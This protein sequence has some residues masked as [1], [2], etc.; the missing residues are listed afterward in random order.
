MKATNGKTI[1]QFQV[2]LNVY[3]STE[4][5]R[6]AIEQVSKL[7]LKLTRI[8]IEYYTFLDDSFGISLLNQVT[9]N[10]ATHYCGF[11]MGGYGESGD[12]V[13]IQVSL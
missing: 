11:T 1:N 4:I 7:G 5:I 8:Q 3:P 12:N 9:C 6:L 13:F 10:D 2:V